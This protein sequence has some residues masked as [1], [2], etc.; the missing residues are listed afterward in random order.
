VLWAKDEMRNQVYDFLDNYVHHLRY[1]LGIEL[2]QGDGRIA[3]HPVD[4]LGYPLPDKGGDVGAILARFYMKKGEWYGELREARDKTYYEHVT[5]CYRLAAEMDQQ[6]YTAWHAW[7]QVN[8]EAV[9]TAE[10]E[11]QPLTAELLVTYIVPAVDGYTKSIALSSG[12]TLQDTLRLLA[13]MFNYGHQQEVC[14]ALN[15]GLHE[16]PVQTWL[17]VIPQ[18]IARIHIR[19]ENV[20]H[21]IQ[22]ILALL[23]KEYPQSLLFSL[24]V[25]SKSES[26]SRQK[27]AMEVMDK[28]KLHDEQLVEEAQMVGAE[29]IR[30]AMLWSEMWQSAIEEASR[31]YYTY[32]NLQGMYDV[33]KHNYQ[34]IQKGPSTIKET[35]FLQT[36]GRELKEA[37]DLVQQYRQTLDLNILNQAWEIY[38]QLFKKF[39]KL[40]P[41]SPSLSLEQ[42]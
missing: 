36:F 38:G 3:P 11:H 10:K 9:Q 42:A 23:G 12:N 28:M 22:H 20:R 18:L 16:V 5:E 39:E 13:L 26:Q 41:K 37:W 14:L 30:A 27:I 2:N 4:P 40:S 31:Q 1:Q 25:A 32:H 35:Q 34:L 6:W 17:Q 15:R 21:L 33:L 7:A 19:Y 24:I 8:Y 29:L